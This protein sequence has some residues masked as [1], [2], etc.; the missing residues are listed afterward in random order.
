MP[1]PAPD[2]RDR[3]KASRRKMTQV[4]CSPQASLDDAKSPAAPGT[5]RLP[6]KIFQIGFNKCG[7]STIHNYLRANGVRSVH[8][9]QGRLARRI[10]ANLANGEDLL[11]GYE[12]FDAFTDMEFLDEAGTF[13]EAY[14]LFPYL[15]A[16]YPDAVFILNTRDRE[17]WIRSR[18][19]HGD[20]RYADRQRGYLKAASD[21]LMAEVWRA[22]WERHHR[23]VT[24]FFAGK[25]H[26]FFLCRIE[27]DLPHRL[28]EMLPECRLNEQ[29]YRLY[30]VRGSRE[31]PSFLRRCANFA[32]RRLS[33]ILGRARHKHGKTLNSA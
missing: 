33:P 21:A 9:D 2:A 31:R 30:K 16:Q 24:E 19:G 10:F 4:M 5:L 22:E 3:R 17:A 27:T 32:Q 26:R 7:T 20:G 6:M 12:D 11:A 25:S 1:P 8:W 28:S 15:A 18:L 13:L 29:H 14:K 23:R